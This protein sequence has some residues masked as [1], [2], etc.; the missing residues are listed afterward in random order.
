M[1]YKPANN[2]LVFP[3]ANKD[4][5]AKAIHARMP[6]YFEYE[7]KDFLDAF[8]ESIQDILLQGKQVNIPKLGAFTISTNGSRKYFNVVE[9]QWKQSYGSYTVKF[10]FSKSIR[11]NI[12]KTIKKLMIA[13]L[14]LRPDSLI[15]DQPHPKNKE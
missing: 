14:K 12:S 10:K 3:K 2:Q 4:E 9:K 6:E 5:L 13:T 15:L 11:D 1:P 8:G 7:I